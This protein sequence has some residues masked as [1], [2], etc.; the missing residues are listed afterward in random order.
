MTGAAADQADTAIDIFTY[1][2]Y[3]ED[4]SSVVHGVATVL[5]DA[6]R[7]A[8]LTQSEVG[9]RAGTSQPAVSRIEAGRSMPDLTTLSRLLLACGQ[10]LQL[11][12]V[13]ISEDEQRQLD[14]SLE[15]TPVQRA[16][17]NQ[18][19]TALAARAAAAPQ[20]RLADLR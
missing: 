1:M 14:E 15:L 2:H 6:R 11:S 13:A 5:R 20:R 4:M 8:G 3:T 12:T 9:R 7:A 19:Q 18:R 16:A 17:R 10:S